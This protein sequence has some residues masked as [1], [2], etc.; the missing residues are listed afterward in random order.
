MINSC[1]WS[2]HWWSIHFMICTYDWIEDWSWR[3]EWNTDKLSRPA[4][5]VRHQR[6]SRIVKL[7][8]VLSFDFH[9]FG[10]L[11]LYKFSQ[12]TE[13]LPWICCPSTRRNCI[14]VWSSARSNMASNPPLRF[15][16]SHR[17]PCAPKDRLFSSF[18]RPDRPGKDLSSGTPRLPSRDSIPT[19]GAF[20][21]L[22]GVPD[23]TST[24][25]SKFCAHI[26]AAQVVSSG[27]QLSRV[28]RLGDRK[29]SI[30]SGGRYWICYSV[31]F[32]WAF[33][34]FERNWEVARQLFGEMSCLPCFSKKICCRKEIAPDE[35]VTKDNGLKK[36]PGELCSCLTNLTLRWCL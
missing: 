17:R 35:G 3:H 36:T 16:R 7:D 32:W 34:A 33:E 28:S 2:A 15:R 12:F 18:L 14:H 23:Q 31:R 10:L 26:S 19:E 4:A 29:A 25:C 5:D 11:F 6:Y 13:L 22:G 21:S 8:R 27:D 1:A 30:S 24:Y 20:S 9:L